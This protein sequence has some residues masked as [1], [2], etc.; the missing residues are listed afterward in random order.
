MTN[1]R[2][3][4]P[5]GHD[6]YLKLWAL[7]RPTLGFEYILLDEAQDTNRVVLG[8]LG[9]QQTQI[10]YVGDRHQQIYEWRGAVNAME[11][12]AHCEQTYLTQSFRFG[13]TVAEAAS[14]VLRTLG[15]TM[16]IRGNP[17]VTSVIAANGSAIAVLA[18]TN[19]TVM[20]EILDALNTNR[21]PCIIGGTDD[22]KRL[23]SDVFE[24]KEN[25][26]GTCPEFFGFQNWAEVVTFSETEEGEDLR[27]FVQLVE[28]HGERS[29]WKA[30]KTVHDDETRADV[31]LSTV[32]KAKG[33]EWDSVRLA[34]DFLSSKP[35]VKEPNP[36]AEARLFYVAMTR[37]KR[38]LFIEPEMLA[39]FTSGIRKPRQSDASAQ[40]PN[41]YSSQPGPQQS[42]RSSSRTEGPRPSASGPTTPPHAPGSNR[43]PTRPAPI[44]EIVPPSV[45]QQHP[46]AASNGVPPTTA[47]QSPQAPRPTTDNTA[48]PPARN[49]FWTRVARLFGDKTA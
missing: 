45:R 3:T 16:P 24:L 4:V 13:Q 47:R 28:R 5:L 46:G 41:G 34:P 26:P 49:N 25:K 19:G 15:E 39:T 36:Q 10:V 7:A 21:R 9:E 2:D 20:A 22:L 48:R 11:K 23:L 29:L 38:Y 8:V 31:V 1:H 12:I 32:H 37:A 30:V 14:R 18:R 42:P 33:R 40:R 44:R 6:G 35:S 27:T 43:V 17:A